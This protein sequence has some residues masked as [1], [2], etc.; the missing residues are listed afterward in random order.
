MQSKMSARKLIIFAVIMLLFGKKYVIAG[1]LAIVIDDI[2]YLPKE[3]NQVL[4]LPKAVSIAILPNSPNGREIAEVAFQQGRE[5]LVH[6]PMLPISR[7]ILEKD[8]L[9]PKMN[10][11]EIQNIIIDAIQRVPHAKGMNNHMGSAM[12]TDLPGMVNVM[13][14][15][16]HYNLFFLDSV[17]IE[18]T[19]ANRV[20]KAFGIP[21]VSRNVFL[22]QEPSVTPHTQLYRAIS[23]VRKNGSA[24][25]IGHPYP[26]TIQTLQQE[27]LELPNDIELVAVSSLFNDEIQRKLN[28]RTIGQNPQFILNEIH[29][30]E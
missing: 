14:T 18:S 13:R 17:T 6:M 22:D 30:N 4:A 27:L 5:I 23:L 2:G 12:T 1:K 26:I 16:S 7:Q 3:D 9:T 28:D 15:L 20:A 25:V 21:T 10:A 8:T 19:K 24:V 29:H 11:S